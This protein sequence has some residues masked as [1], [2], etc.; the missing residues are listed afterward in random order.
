MKND[1]CNA[2][3]VTHPHPHPYTNKIHGY[4]LSSP[5][6]NIYIQIERKKISSKGRIQISV[7]T[8]CQPY[9]STARPIHQRLT[10]ASSL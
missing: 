1:P 9:Q 2:S 10:K 4:C 7:E 6:F 5:I 3:Q 8:N